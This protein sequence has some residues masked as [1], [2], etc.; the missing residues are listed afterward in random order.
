MKKIILLYLISFSIHAQKVK[1]D[2]LV[3]LHASLNELNFK[4]EKFSEI[5]FK[6]FYQKL[7]SQSFNVKKVNFKKV[8][9][10][11]HTIQDLKIKLDILAFDV[12][13]KKINANGSFITKAPH[14]YYSK[15]FDRKTIM[16]VSNF[17]LK[18]SV[19]NSKEIND[20]VKKV[21]KVI[22]NM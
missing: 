11:H 12:L 17:Q 4:F 1:E 21:K 9:S 22:D 10:C 5:E 6:S 2:E 14:Y 3:K 19:H 18:E 13:K 20:F 8:S 16:L 15:T 7:F